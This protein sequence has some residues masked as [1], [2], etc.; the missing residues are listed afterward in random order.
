M[1]VVKV[2]VKGNTEVFNFKVST[3]EG[4]FCYACYA[5]YAN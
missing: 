2:I 3:K 1:V 4:F 5:C